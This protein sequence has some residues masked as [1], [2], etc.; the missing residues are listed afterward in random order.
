MGPALA[1]KDK[2]TVD[3]CTRAFKVKSV[4]HNYSNGLWIIQKFMQN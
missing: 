1:P 3:T 2:I 4:T